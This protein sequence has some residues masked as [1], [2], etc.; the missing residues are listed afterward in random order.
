MY[1]WNLGLHDSSARKEAASNAG[2]PGSI[3][4]S[5][6]SIGEGMG[7]PLQ[8]ARA[9]LV[10]QLVKNLP[11]CRRPGFDPWVGKIPWRRERVPTT[12]F[13]TGEFH[14]LYS[15]WGHKELDTTEQRLSNFHFL[16]L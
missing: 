7:Y 4:G 14:G 13:W 8:S 3:P 11:Q 16:Y 10:L 2:N 9:S 1:T 15:P 5:G 12:I 6:R